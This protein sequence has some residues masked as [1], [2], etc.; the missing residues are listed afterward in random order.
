M[1]QTRII[2]KN[3]QQAAQ[4]TARYTQKKKLTDTPSPIQHETGW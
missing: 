1:T 2:Q 4:I 3:M